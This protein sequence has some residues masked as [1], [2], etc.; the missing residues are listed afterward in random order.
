MC[1]DYLGTSRATSPK[2]SFG[3]VTIGAN[4]SYAVVASVITILVRNHIVMIFRNLIEMIFFEIAN[5]QGLVVLNVLFVVVG[6]GDHR[7][8]LHKSHLRRHPLE[9]ITFCLAF[10]RILRKIGLVMMI[11]IL[12]YRQF[13]SCLLLWRHLIA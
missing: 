12:P 6:G 13:K 2:R 4:P 7:L 9:R 5:V 1:G 10:C 8:S 3:R 11:I